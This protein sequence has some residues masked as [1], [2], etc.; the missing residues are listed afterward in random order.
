MIFQEAVIHC[1]NRKELMITRSFAEQARVREVLTTEGIDYVV[2][3]K[4]GQ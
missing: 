3:V 4:G 2:K 1:F